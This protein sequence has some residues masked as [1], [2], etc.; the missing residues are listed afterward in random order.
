M[1][2]HCRHDYG[3]VELTV[4][5]AEPKT[6]VVPSVRLRALVDVE[7]A[8]VMRSAWFSLAALEALAGAAERPAEAEVAIESFTP[9][10]LAIIVAGAGVRFHCAWVPASGLLRASFDA[11]FETGELPKLGAWLRKLL[12]PGYLEALRY[13]DY[14]EELCDDSDGKAP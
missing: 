3:S 5:E 11:R 14:D 8:R 1:L 10:D 9:G 7:G 4:C 2:I 12:K 6:S 13:Y